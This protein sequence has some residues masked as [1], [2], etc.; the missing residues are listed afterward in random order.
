MLK[1]KGLMTKLILLGSGAAALFAF[2]LIVFDPAPAAACKSPEVKCVP[3][4]LGSSGDLAVLAGAAVT[5][6]DSNV[7]GDVGVYPG[8][9]ITQTNC[10]IDGAV[11]A[12]DSAASA[13]YLDFISAYNDFS[14]QAC[15]QILSG[16]LADVILAPG[17]YCFDAAATLTGLLTLDGPA[18]GVWI[19]RIGIVGTGALTGTG[20]SMVMAGGGSPCNV[21]W[22][23]A[24][25]VTMTDSEFLGNVLA[26]AAITVTGG[27]LEGNLFA[28]A[29]VTM[30]NAF[31]TGCEP[32]I[33]SNRC[34]KDNEYRN[35]K[36]CK[37]ACDDMKGE[38]GHGHRD[39]RH[40]GGHDWR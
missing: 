23:V 13:A 35:I 10:T 17:V 12:R 19:F 2:F 26:G 11:H 29:A 34:E 7:A 32:L 37:K 38:R 18:D 6:T 16:T 9:A 28:Q 14:L 31:V 1:H 22:Q 33:Q 21:Y 30:T 40:D 4:Y 15:D 25:A 24:E 39:S 8:T 20:F 3:E 5:C 27:T 36:E